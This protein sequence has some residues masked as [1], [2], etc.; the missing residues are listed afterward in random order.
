MKRTHLSMTLVFLSMWLVGA[1]RLGAQSA[2]AGTV[3]PEYFAADDRLGAYIADALTR[4]PAIR[5]AAA[6]YRAALQLVPQVRE[7]PDPMLTFT[8]A[9]RSVETR[10]GPQHRTVMLS[11][12]FPWFGTLALREQVAVQAA[13]AQYHRY[14]ASQRDVIVDVKQA[15]YDLGY[16]DTAVAI[17]REE[18]SLLEHYEQLAQARFATGQGLQQGVI[19]LQAAIT[20]VINRMELL[21]QQRATLAARINT[22]RNEPPEQ[23]IP[24]V[25]ALALPLVTL[26]L[27]R[28]YAVAD[29]HGPDLQA[30]IA[31]IERSER[32][33]ALAQKAFWPTV[34]LGVGFQSIGGRADPAGRFAPPPGS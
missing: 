32:A 15:F 29:Q 25:G 14:V 3:H 22:L 21:N 13:A 28:L 8:Q 10:V 17:T 12:A 31:L 4:N 7:L 11:Q 26:D 34:T 27:E 16:V 24:R 23:P 9:L 30:G 1:D 18:Q 6:R 2:G 33:I 19:R 20:Q 5:E